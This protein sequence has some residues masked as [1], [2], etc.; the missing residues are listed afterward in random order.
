MLAKDRRI[1][2]RPAEIEAI[3]T[4]RV[5]AFVLTS[6]NLTAAQQIARYLANETRISEACEN[7]GPFVF[8]VHASRIEKIYPPRPPP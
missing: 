5:K 4:H 1:R 8:A 7:D 3:R 6:G 2:Y